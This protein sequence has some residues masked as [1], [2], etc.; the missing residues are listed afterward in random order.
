ME[1]DERANGLGYGL[2]SQLSLDCMRHPKGKATVKSLR[3]R[4]EIQK[5]I[6]SACP[7]LFKGWTHDESEI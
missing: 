4:K 2:V 6:H 7:L 5:K 1:L 3:H